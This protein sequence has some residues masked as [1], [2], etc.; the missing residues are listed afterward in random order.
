MFFAMIPSTALIIV[1]LFLLSRASKE[2][3]LHAARGCLVANRYQA[4][5]LEN[6]ARKN[7]A[8]V[9]QYHGLSAKVVALTLDTDVSKQVKKLAE[10]NRAIQSGNMAGVSMLLIP[11][12]VVMRMFPNLLT[13]NIYRNIRACYY[14]L[15]GKKYPDLLARQLLAKLT[16]YPLIGAGVS[17]AAGTIMAIVN[18]FM[19]GMAIM[20]LGTLIVL[21]LVYS[22]YDDLNDLVKARRDAI[23]RQFPNV[24]SKLALLV[25]SGMIMNRAWNETAASNEGELYKEM[26]LTADELSNLVPPEEAYGAFIDRCN[27]KETTKLASAIMQNL[28][29]GNSEIGVLLRQMSAEAWNERRNL[30]KR[31][32]ENANSKMM[33]PTMLIFG[34]ILLM[35]MVPMIMSFSG[36]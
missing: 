20:V 9:A 7:R 28:S 32:S 14:E 15:Y 4:E 31:D 27:T 30:A 34:S 16:S 12:Y 35:I 13:G 3:W 2:D 19:I 26:R 10:T 36:I 5:E 23:C 21:V 17:L 25:T 11:G 18:D 1:W 33:I 22:M 8:K 24:V 29:K 6:T